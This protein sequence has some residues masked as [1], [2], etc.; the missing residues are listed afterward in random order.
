MANNNKHRKRAQRPK[1]ID[2]H[3]SA[4]WD[5][6]RHSAGLPSPRYNRAEEKRVGWEL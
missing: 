5:K 1:R 3:T 6:Y 4:S 2:R